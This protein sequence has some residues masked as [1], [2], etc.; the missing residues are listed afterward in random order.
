[1][2]SLPFLCFAALPQHLH[3]T[4]EILSRSWNIFFIYSW[5]CFYLCFCVWECAFGAGADVAS[6]SQSTS[7]CFMNHQQP[8][9]YRLKNIQCT[10][11]EPSPCL[12]MQSS[13]IK[14]WPDVWNWREIEGEIGLPISAGVPWVPIS[15][16]VGNSQLI[17]CTTRTEVLIGRYTHYPACPCG[18]F[19]VFYPAFDP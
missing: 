8:M 1:M 4:K 19:P 13:R 7:C 18:H 16:L 2:D 9:D 10:G 12:T 15:W 5:F 14:F 11:L 3:L 6:I 17:P